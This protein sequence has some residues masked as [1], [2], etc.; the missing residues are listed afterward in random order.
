MALWQISIWTL[1]LACIGNVH[2]GIEDYFKPVSGKVKTDQ[3]RNIDFIY[4]INLDKRPEKFASCLKKLALHHISPYRFSAVNGWDLSLESLN[5]LGIKFS[6]WMDSRM[7]TCYL[8]E[9]NG[10]ASHEELCVPGRNY[11]SHCMSRGAVGIVLSHLSILSDAYQSGFETIWIMEDDIE[12]IRDPHVLSDLIDE[13]DTLVGKNGWDILF[14]DLD[15]KGNDG[16]RVPC[17]SYAWRPNFAP[18]NVYRFAEK[19]AISPHLR[20]IGSRYGAYSMIVRRSGMQ[21]ILNFFSH[22]QIFLPYDM[23]YTQPNDIHLYTVIDDVV[24]TQINAISDN[25][26]PN[27][28]QLDH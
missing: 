25:G 7:G 14:T 28:K 12:V 15:T 17:S 9:D 5:E 23:E 3:M 2:A 26:A 6:P 13:L 19:E 27:Y 20:R 11:F 24:S 1:F 21:K 10:K 4:M 18:L 22:Y 8:P 16:N